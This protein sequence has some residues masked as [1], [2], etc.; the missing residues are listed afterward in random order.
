MQGSEVNESE[1]DKDESKF[2][3]SFQNQ[4]LNQYQSCK[5]NNQKDDRKCNFSAHIDRMAN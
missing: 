3:S 2:N 4:Y 5:I 1:K